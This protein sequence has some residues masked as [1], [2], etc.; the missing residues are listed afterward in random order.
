MEERDN[1]KRKRG[2]RGTL[3]AT[4]RTSTKTTRKSAVLPRRDH[5]LDDDS[6]NNF[7]EDDG[8]QFSSHTHGSTEGYDIFQDPPKRSPNAQGLWASYSPFPD[9]SVGSAASALSR[10]QDPLEETG[11]AFPAPRPAYH[12]F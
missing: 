7:E 6:F 4:R 5:D 9:S 1:H 8:N 12:W 11:F 10:A 3:P 2:R